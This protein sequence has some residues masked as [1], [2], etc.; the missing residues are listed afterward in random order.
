ME[1]NDLIL[2]TKRY[3]IRI[4][5]LVEALPRTQAGKTIGNQFI[6]SGTSIGANYRA[7]CRARSLADFI[8]KIGIV[9]EET[10]ESAFWLEL[11]VDGKL[12]KEELVI[13][14]L[15]E[16]KEILAIMIASSNTARKNKK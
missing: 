13:N 6:Q 2:R 1:E 3:A 15:Q 10:D 5:K 12:L 7:A 16:T 4:F 8:S 14:L 11:I 9:I